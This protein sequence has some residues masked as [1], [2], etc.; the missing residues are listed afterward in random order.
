MRHFLNVV[1]ITTLVIL[2]AS[3]LFVLTVILLG[4]AVRG[5][6]RFGRRHRRG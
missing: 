5:W 3:A 6:R 2:V 4:E 1:L